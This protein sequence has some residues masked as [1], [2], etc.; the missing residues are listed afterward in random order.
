ML[1]NHNKEN[2]Q[3]S[4]LSRKTEPKKP[5]L[6]NSINPSVSQSFQRFDNSNGLVIAHT[7]NLRY[8]NQLAASSDGIVDTLY[9]NTEGSQQPLSEET[10]LP[11]SQNTNIEKFPFV[12]QTQ[13]NEEC[14][15]IET[16]IRENDVKNDTS[17]GSEMEYNLG[18]FDGGMVQ[19][20]MNTPE[21]F[22]QIGNKKCKYCNQQLSGNAYSLDGRESDLIDLGLSTRWNENIDP[23]LYLP[24]FPFDI[25]YRYQEN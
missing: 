6:S 8:D 1:S 17:E 4:G 19:V 3:S 13:F 16:E 7:F 23:E 14:E 2:V 20:E 9:C 5:R 25:Q 21:K 24:I 10:K 22:V 12:A 18:N 15:Y 11:L